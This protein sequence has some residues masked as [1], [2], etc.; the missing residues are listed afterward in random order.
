MVDVLFW[1]TVVK[2]GMQWLMFQSGTRQSNRS[3]VVDVLI[4]NTAVKQ[5]CSG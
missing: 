2:S 5:E 4:W 1:N 3:A